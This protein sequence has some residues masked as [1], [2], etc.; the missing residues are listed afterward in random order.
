MAS[1]INTSLSSSE[2][3]ASAQNS[4]NV[5]GYSSADRVYKQFNN[6]QGAAG[7]DMNSY[8]GMSTSRFYDAIQSDQKLEAGALKNNQALKY[9][10]IAGAV[11]V[12][13]IAIIA[14][15]GRA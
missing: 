13:I 2:N 5:G 14:Y 6:V 4:G 10:A 9:S 1:D 7:L 8:F 12:S 11:V 15:K 3:D